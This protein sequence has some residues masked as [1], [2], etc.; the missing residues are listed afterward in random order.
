MRLLARDASTEACSVALLVGD[1]MI[2]RHEEGT[3]GQAERLLE[4]IAELLAEA[5][6]RPAALDAIAAGVGPGAFTGVRLGVAVAQGLAFGASLPVVP[7]TTLE[8]LAWPAVAA[9]PVLACLDARMGEVY[10]GCYRADPRRGVAPLIAPCVGPIES[11]RLLESMNSLESVNLPASMNPLESVRADALAPR[12]GVGRGFAAY[13]RLAALAG[14]EVSGSDARALPDARDLAR[15]G[16]LRVALGEG[17][18]PAALAPL[19]VRDKVAAT[20]AE[21]GV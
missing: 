1:Q 15:L 3:G 4:L 8:A 18:D 21:R 14:V 7:I 6:L 13:P 11:V 20:E 12:R 2:H 9:G 5:G 19:Y 16:V 10:W 17:I